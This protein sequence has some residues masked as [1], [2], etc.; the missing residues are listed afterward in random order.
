MKRLIYLLLLLPFIGRAQVSLVS[1]SNS[2]QINSVSYPLNLLSLNINH[3][4]L[5][6]ID[7]A[8]PISQYPYVDRVVIKNQVISNCYLNGTQCTDTGT[9]RSFYLSYFVGGSGGGSGSGLGQFYQVDIGT[10]GAILPFGDSIFITNQGIDTKSQ[11]F[12]QWGDLTNANANAVAIGQ[13]MTN[14]F[15]VFENVNGGVANFDVGSLGTSTINIEFQTT[16]GTIAYTSDVISTTNGGTGLTS[17]SVGDVIIGNGSN[18]FT[19]LPIG[20]SGLS[21]VSNGT[22]VSWGSPTITTLSSI[23]SYGGVSTSGNGMPIFVSSI[24][25]TSQ[26]AATTIASYS[27]STTGTYEV[28]GYINITAV[29]LDVIQFQCSWKDEN[30]TSRT[31]NFFPM[32]LTTPSLS[33]TGFTPFPSIYIRCHSASNITVQTIL[34]TGTGSISY[35]CGERIKQD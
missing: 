21:L 10:N 33:S 22:T 12:P 26:V 13:D 7:Y 9:L 29:S 20:A 31:Q 1:A 2:I 25:L 3:D 15:V 18:S 6:E 28:G 32:G 16:D 4:T 35:D 14:G 8:V 17:N 34:T 23:T 11:T 27:A 24:D 30:G 19:N 5:F